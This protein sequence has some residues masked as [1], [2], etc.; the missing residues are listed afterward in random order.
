MRGLGA[1]DAAFSVNKTDNA[2]VRLS[3]RSV[4]G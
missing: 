1:V 4:S 2:S 3:G